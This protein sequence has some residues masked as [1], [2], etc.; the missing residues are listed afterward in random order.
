MA[1]NNTCCCFSTNHG[2]FVYILTDFCGFFAGLPSGEALD[3]Y[4]SADDYSSDDY[5]YSNDNDDYLNKNEQVV[6][7]TPTLIST[8]SN[9]LVNEGDTIKLPCLVD[10]LGKKI[11][12][13]HLQLHVK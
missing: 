11:F 13:L 7:T 5:N 1:K 4:Y 9:Q 10:K 8:S 12:A 2:H 3:D 6:L